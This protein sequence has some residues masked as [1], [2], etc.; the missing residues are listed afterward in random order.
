MGRCIASRNGTAAI[1][2][3]RLVAKLKAR[4][5]TQAA[6]YGQV[7]RPQEPCRD[8]SGDGGDHQGAAPAQAWQFPAGHRCRSGSPRLCQRQRQSVLSGVG[9]LNAGAPK[10]WTDA[11]DLRQ[12][13]HCKADSRIAQLAAILTKMI[14]GKLGSA[15]RI[16]INHAAPAGAIERRPFAF[17]LRQ[18][19]GDRIEGGRVMAHAAM[20]A[21][22]LDAF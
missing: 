13:F 2:K 3:A 9:G 12:Q 14:N 6:H 19:I 18:A 15:M 22:D 16:R 1:E 11:T 4:A 7:R 20:A 8:Q 5:R 10:A 21:F 17:R